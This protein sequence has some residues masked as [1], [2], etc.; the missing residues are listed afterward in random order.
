MISV[1]LW[2]ILKGDL[3]EV[4][5]CV[6]LF[7]YFS[8]LLALLFPRFGKREL[9]LVLFVRLF[10]L[11]LFGFVC[12]SIHL[13]DWDGLRLVALPGLFSYL[14][15]IISFLLLKAINNFWS[16]IISL[17]RL[18]V[19]NNFSHC[20]FSFQRQKIIN[21]VYSRIFSFQRVKIINN[22]K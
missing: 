3:F 20:I 12:F 19:I 5:H 6:I 14:F 17:K 10:D 7:L 11:C 16:C 13:R 4:L 18:K 22:Y 2:F 15:C 1:A 9:I 8:V 21:I